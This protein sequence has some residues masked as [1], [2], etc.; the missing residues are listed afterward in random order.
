MELQFDQD[1]ALYDWPGALELGIAYL[2]QVPDFLYFPEFGT[3]TSSEGSQRVALTSYEVAS[4]LSYLIWNSMPDETLLEL[5]RAD[6]LRDRETVVAQAWRMLGDI[7]AQRGVLGFY[8]QL[9]DL[10]KIGTT[11]LDF[12]VYLSEFEG[13]AG[14]DY[15]HQILQPAMRFEPEI[16]VTNEIFRGSGSLAG[17]LSANHT[18]ITPPLA[19]LYGVEIDEN[20]EA[21]A[22]HSEFSETL[23]YIYEGTFY[24]TQLNGNERAG[25][26][27]MLGFLNSHSKLTHPSPFCA[28]S[29]F[30][31]VFYVHR[32]RPRLAMYRRLRTPTT[33][34]SPGLTES[35]MPII[36]TTLRASHVMR[37]STASAS[38]S[39]TT[40]ASVNG[41][42]TTT[43]IQSM[44][45]A[46][47]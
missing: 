34:K 5:A 44:R 15:L 3:G 39:K 31:N 40:M 26:L 16:F 25:V 24:K 45:L 13:D 10:D 8:K 30:K 47:Y 9:L 18:F 27:T 7:K 20:S 37:A 46:R 1:V 12:S 29:L 23:D 33:V 36:P 11:S 41:A 35:V 2:L 6:K 28:G 22:W 4:R 32:P 17:L 19:E 42:I 14:S 43:V 38:R 21:V